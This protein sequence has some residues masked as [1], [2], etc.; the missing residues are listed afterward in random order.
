MDDT[1]EG[2][3]V[4]PSP[5][6]DAAPPAA[7]SGGMPGGKE[8]ILCGE[9]IASF[10]DRCAH[11]GGF[12]PIAEGRAFGHHF[13]FLFCCMSIFIGTLLPWE[14]MWWHSYV[15]RSIHGGFLLALWG[16]GLVA[17]YFNI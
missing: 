5:G 17:A 4:P 14:G 3:G 6:S 1:P 9:G 16:Y 13:F 8:C 7:A 11:C 12:L 10:A 15:W 2:Q